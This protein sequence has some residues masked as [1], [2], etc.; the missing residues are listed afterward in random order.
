MLNE[1]EIIRRF[2]KREG[3]PTRSDVRLGIDDDGAV[4]C[5]PPGT[6]L[7]SAIDTMVEGRHFPVGTPP[8]DI[9]WKAL[10]VNLS[11]LAAMGAEPAWFTLALTVPRG[12][13]TWLRGF[14]TGLFELA[15]RY[16]TALVGGDT[17][18]GPL[19]VSIAV[20]GLV[21]AGAALTRAGAQPGDIVCATGT[22]G[23]AALALKHVLRGEPVDTVLAR[24]LSRPEPRVEAGLALRAQANAGIDVSDGLAADL[25]H[26]L[27]A[28]GVGATIQ[29]DELPLSA[30]VR[31]LPADEAAI[32]ALSGGDDYELCVC[33]PHER[34]AEARAA[35]SGDLTPIGRIEAQPGL[36]LAC[37]D[38]RPFKLEH[39]GY[40]HFD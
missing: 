28:S 33:I 32:L 21:P 14:A 20:H 11:D 10:A 36:R 30:A 40:A 39:A 24:R 25:K 15:D 34:L 38:G 12:D 8:Q 16:D 9:G 13:E 6:D 7:V 35:V 26:V 27:E 4:L 3:R 5:I 31:A 22:L 18:R 29:V 1:F 37:A 23:D 2:F 19:T 17:T